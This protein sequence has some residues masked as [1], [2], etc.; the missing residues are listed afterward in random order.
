MALAFTT[1]LYFPTPGTYVMG[2][3]SDDSSRVTMARNSHDLL[4][5]EIPG[6]HAEGGRGIGSLQNVGA[7][8]VTNAG[9]YGFRL[10][11]EN[12]GGGAGVEWYFTSTPAGTT[13]VLI[14][15]LNQNPQYAVRAFQVSSAAPPY[16]S[17][18]EPPL[19]DDLVPAN[20]TIQYKIS[21]A[22]T[23]VVPGSVALKI[24]GAVQSPA[25]TTGGGVTSLSLPAPAT[26][27]PVG[28]NNIELSFKDSAGATND[29]RYSFVV[30]AYATLDPSQ[31]V[32][33]GSQDATKP[34]F[35]LTTTHLLL[36]AASYTG[37]Q[38]TP[39]QSD[40]ANAEIA[41]LFY[42]TYGVNGS[43]APGP[44]PWPGVID[45]AINGSAGDF[46]NNYPL[47]GVGTNS[48]NTTDN[49]AAY[50]QFWLAFPTA[51]FYR[52]GVSSDDGY[53]VS[54]GFDHIRQVLHVSGTGINKDV[55]AVV[56]TTVDGNG[57]YGIVPPVTPIVAPVMVA[58]SNTVMSSLSGKIAVFDRGLF[59]F[60]SEDLC[61]IAQTNGAVGFIIIDTPANGFPY[62]PSGTLTNPIT[63]PVLAVSGYNGDRD[64]WIT[65]ANLTATI[66]ASQA[67]ELGGA[68]YGKGMGWV[69]FSVIV[70]SAGLYP[71][72][73]IYYNGGGGAGIE[74][75]SISPVDGSRTLINDT[76]NPNALLA[77]QAVTATAK[78]TV[79]IGKLG[80]TLT[81]TF[82]GKLQSSSTVNGGYTDVAGATNPYTVPNT[83]GAQ[84]YRTH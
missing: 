63:I 27:W 75:A 81:I 46:T 66:G 69:D 54:E 44:S 50:F 34:G 33:L 38:G 17:Y 29:Y 62:R 32:P 21:D 40:V 36:H 10:L 73:V 23:T 8:I 7:I 37:S 71:L 16:V 61:V 65:N 20:A 28:T 39:N 76:S 60:G 35:V 72:N 77:Y 31:S 26:L 79:S 15:D 1:Y 25:L 58:N 80:N 2:F 41:G 3:N 12:G 18:A 55:G 22:G 78:P 67:I 6:L 13:N 24:N 57:G 70:P 82:T 47:P 11:Y 59:G 42:P 5:T 49:I 83:T 45:F 53:R 56:S 30:P 64:F 74:F 48:D 19:D 4:G 68:D 84:F 51:G 52:M 43:T 14:N 9:Y